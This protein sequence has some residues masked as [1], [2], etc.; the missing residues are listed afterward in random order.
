M[1]TWP[2]AIGAEKL[3][4]PVPA[5]HA[6]CFVDA[7]GIAKSTVAAFGTSLQAIGLPPCWSVHCTAFM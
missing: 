7:P 1:L 2:V 6:K 3:K 4:A 5:S